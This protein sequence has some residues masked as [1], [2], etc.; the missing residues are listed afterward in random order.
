MSSKSQEEIGGR[1]A[2]RSLR[3]ELASLKIDRKEDRRAVKASPSPRRDDEPRPVR[4]RGPG[5]ALRLLTLLLWMVP[6]GVIGGGA[7]VAYV[8]Y[9][10]TKAQIEVRTTT[11]DSISPVEARKI[12]SAKGYLK[13]RYQAMI[14]ARTPGRVEK[15]LVEEG[16]K[17][18]KGDLL[19]VLEH[20]DMDAT[21]ESRRASIIRVE[22]DVAAAQADL[23]EK[24]RKA[25]LQL[26]VYKRQQASA[27]DVEEANAAR[28][29]S[30]AQVKS[31]E[32]NVKFMAPRPGR[33]R[34]RSAT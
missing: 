24:E 20:N 30:A 9:K 31:L 28:D 21:L 1:V 25:R 27:N 17:V 34:P 23:K 2:P 7:Y 3:D 6:L 14:G 19:A 32:A 16:T 11:V 15:M 5:F 10:K 13:S 26:S 18:H 33:S 12:L 29:I 8:Q 4:K 22:A